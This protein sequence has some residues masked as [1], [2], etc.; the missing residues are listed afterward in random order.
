MTLVQ[1]PGMAQSL[2]LG[3]E[4]GLPAFGGVVGYGQRCTR[5]VGKLLCFVSFPG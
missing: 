4:A 2:N 1:K 5:F 3:T